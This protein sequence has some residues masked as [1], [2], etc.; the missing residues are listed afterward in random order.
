MATI[1]TNQVEIDI[2]PE[3]L[4]QYSVFR[5]DVSA[6]N[7]KDYRAKVQYI[8][9]ELKAISLLYRD[10]QYYGL[11]HQKDERRLQKKHRI[12]SV[13]HYKEI[14]LALLIKAIPVL[15]N[16]DSNVELDGYY[17][18]FSLKK[19]SKNNPNAIHLQAF[20]IGYNFNQ[21]AI[22]IGAVSFS[23]LAFHEANPR[24]Y[25]Q[26]VKQPRYYLNHVDASMTR[27]LDDAAQND[28]TPY[29][30][31]KLFDNAQSTAAVL[32]HPTDT[33]ERNRLDEY[34]SLRRDLQNTYNGLVN[35][36][37]TQE[38]ATA[39][40]EGGAKNRFEKIQKRQ[41]QDIR[42][43]LRDKI[44]IEDHSGLNVNLLELVSN[45]NDVMSVNSAN[46]PLTIKIIRDKDYYEKEKIDDPYQSSANTQHIIWPKDK[47]GKMLSTN[48]KKAKLLLDTA[49]KELAFKFELQQE[50]FVLP[51][52]LSDVN[53]QAYPNFSA[54]IYEKSDK[55]KPCIAELKHETGNISLRMLK[56]SEIDEFVGSIKPVLSPKQQNEGFNQKKYYFLVSNDCIYQ[57]DET[58]LIA[59]PNLPDYE[60]AN[61]NPDIMENDKRNNQLR[62]ALSE[63]VAAFRGNYKLSHGRYFGA[64]PAAL[65]TTSARFA[66][67]YQIHSNGNVVPDW[68]YDSIINYTV[69]HKQS[70]V[71]P[72]FYKHLLEFM[73]YSDS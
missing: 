30:R 58:E 50:R 64:S 20:E 71:I 67:I 12:V 32:V 70:T 68:I 40:I 19:K 55:K 1:Y 8:K 33:S 69:K 34:L 36:Q 49:I 7:N 39:I 31:R 21:R 16:L 66:R 45:D 18:P 46:R 43:M 11:F 52:H 57:F 9:G 44:S 38:Q 53:Q 48:D 15:N 6:I 35:I 62:G 56:P 24:V 14:W 10:K 25:K 63:T 27:E 28:S 54:Y 37:Y 41:Y 51:N 23:P 5:C 72:F 3:I 60:Y 65:N 26:A 42:E 73:R 59:M 22:T 17:K 29:V 61:A 4:E 13:N 47:K 2:K